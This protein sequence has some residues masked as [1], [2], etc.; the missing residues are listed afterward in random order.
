MYDTANGLPNIHQTAA[1]NSTTDH[2]A[3]P[4]PER[5]AADAMRRHFEDSALAS[6]LPTHAAFAD[7]EIVT[8]DM[9]A[10][11]PA[12]HG[13]DDRLHSHSPSPAL[14]TEQ[15]RKRVQIVK[16]KASLEDFQ[17][18]RVSQVTIS[19]IKRGDL[20]EIKTIVGDIFFRVLD[21]IKG[22]AAGV[23]EVLCE[24]RYDL[25][26][27][28]DLV[29]AASIILPI[30]SKNHLITNPDGTQ[31]LASRSLKLTTGTEL[32][33]QVKNLLRENFFVEIKIHANPQPE[34]LRA[35]DALRW[36]KR[37]A[38]KLKAI[39]DE[40]NK[41]ERKKNGEGSAP[42]KTGI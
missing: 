27:Q 10:G 7:A 38:L 40:N 21:R 11:L 16:L 37:L 34:K 12:G 3:L 18:S 2:A 26:D 30:C 4:A 5:R 29:H 36:A 17:V 15:V 32:P 8:I 9:D 1:M 42:E 35:I 6:V 13:H 28:W 39:I 22:N 24:C 33:G 14:T 19:N 25:L 20:I 31:R 41:R 23:G